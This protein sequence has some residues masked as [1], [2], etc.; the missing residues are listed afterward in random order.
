MTQTRA[1]Q[2]A[3]AIERG[4][5]EN[6]FCTVQDIQ[7]ELR[8]LSPMENQLIATKAMHHDEQLHSAQVSRGLDKAKARIKELEDALSEV[9]DSSC[10]NFTGTPSNKAFSILNKALEQTTGGKK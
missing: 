3:K 6:T 9:W 10:T 7:A 1:E 8:R 2:L 5:L 4:R